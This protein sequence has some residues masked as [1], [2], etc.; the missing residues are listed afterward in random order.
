[1]S[2]Y[3]SLGSDEW[4]AFL[5]GRRWF[6]SKATVKSARVRDVIELPWEGGGSDGQYAVVRLDVETDAGRDLYQVPLQHASD[7]IRPAEENPV[8]LRHLASALAR[9]GSYG[10]AGGVRWVIAPESEQ[11]LVVPVDAPVRV[12]TGEQSNT[13]IMFDDEG[14]LKLFRRLETAGGGE[15]PDIELTRYLTVDAGF[16]H[17]PTLLGT[18]R[19]EETGM[20]PM[21]AGMLQEYLPDSQDAWTY[22]L[23]RARSYFAGAPDAPNDFT[24]D[25]RRLGAITREMHDLLARAPGALA[26]EATTAADVER[27]ADGAREWV[28]RATA[29]LAR[30]LEQERAGR[31]AGWSRKQVA[32]AEVL[33]RR[34]DDYLRFVDELARDSVAAEGEARPGRGDGGAGGQGEPKIRIHG[35]YHLGQV[36][37][38]AG[39]D[40]VIIDFEGEPARPLA[41]R[42]EKTSPMRD[43]AG[44]LRSFAY[45]A[46]ATQ[47]AVSDARGGE[48]DPELEIRA[49]RWERDVRAAFLAGYLGTDDAGAA[50]AGARAGAS[51]LVSLFETE[52]V[53]YELTYELNN[54]PDWVWIP[55]RGISKL[56]VRA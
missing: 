37:R 21:M 39:K 18:I 35:D 32:E 53:F 41:E 34:R 6:G 28:R 36:L 5:R 14:I 49:A 54:R 26:A 52:K 42:R 38:T 8:F 43:V 9:G 22:A 40:Y 48:V 24:V 27:W 20:P 44:M 50:P 51:R 15:H 3:D 29:V 7:G 12:A 30:Q 13:S 2:V 56:L 31:G 17:T 10:D 47:T 4:V 23:E 46:A 25:A 55:M 19:F 16:A 45:A 11:G 1:M 33:A